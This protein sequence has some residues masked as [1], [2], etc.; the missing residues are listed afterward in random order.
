NTAPA[1]AQAKSILSTF[2][3]TGASTAAGIS[4]DLLELGNEPDLYGTNEHRTSGYSISQYVSESIISATGLKT[5]VRPFILGLSFGHSDHGVGEFSPQQAFADGY[6]TTNAGKFV[7]IISQHNYEGGCCTA[8]VSNLLSKSLTRSNLTAFTSDI[9]AVKAKGLKYIF[10]ETNSYFNHGVPPV[11]DT[12]GAAVWVVDYTLFA[13][14]LGIANMFFHEGIG[15][16]YN[17]FQPVSL[18]RSIE[19]ATPL[20]PPVAAHVQP[21]Y[22]AAIVIAEFL[23]SSTRNLVELST[24]SNI[25]S[26]YALYSGTSISRVLLINHE[27]FLSSSSGSARP[28]VSVFF[29]LSGGGK[30]VQI[31]RLSI[32]F[33]DSKSGLKWGGQSYETSNVLVNGSLVTTSQV[34]TDPIV[35]SA[36]EVVMVTF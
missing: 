26:A 19:D 4:L 8:L 12:G 11:S 34:L 22:Y 24:T 14:T 13:G 23:G 35:V 7:T 17:L 21:A 1:I 15:F 36:T 5:G 27:A 25:I 29:S 3:S 32:P 16:K 31:K 18:N 30:T 10:G 2:S 20:N 28:S 33:A 9:Q 6:L